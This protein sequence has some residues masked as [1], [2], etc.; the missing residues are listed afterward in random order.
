MS[1][2]AL[3]RCRGQ[4]SPTP[5]SSSATPADTPTTSSRVLTHPREPVLHT[6]HRGPRQRRLRRHPHVPR[7]ARA[8]HGDR[9][10]GRARAAVRLIRA[11]PDLAARDAT[12]G[13]R[14][15]RSGVLGAHGKA[16][17]QAAGALR[18]D[19]RGRDRALL[20]TRR[21]ERARAGADALV[22]QLH[23]ARGVCRW[24]GHA[25]PRCGCR[26]T[27][28]GEAE[29]RARH[30]AREGDRGAVGAVL[31][32]GCVRGAGAERLAAVVGRGGGCHAGGAVGGLIGCSAAAGR[33]RSRR[34]GS[35]SPWTTARS[36]SGRRSREL[37]VL[38]ELRR[39]VRHWRSTTPVWTSTSSWRPRRRSGSS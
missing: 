38:V 39:N 27:L 36:S 4:R 30:R 6:A 32:R 33:S 37:R 17:C 12:Q 14:P 18:G 16:R 34:P 5:T 2:R 29:F 35:C 26:L 23:T 19:V 22:R 21:G 10:R 20:V 28:D 11:R 3:T 31:P 25:R 8:A 24:C 1:T 13:N 15:T 9:H 7:R